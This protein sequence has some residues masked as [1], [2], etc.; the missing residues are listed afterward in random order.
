MTKDINEPHLHVS[1][2]TC[3]EALLEYREDITF[4]EVD[5]AIVAHERTTGC[6]VEEVSNTKEDV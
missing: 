2:I 1:C 4:A 5:R 3:G 6:G